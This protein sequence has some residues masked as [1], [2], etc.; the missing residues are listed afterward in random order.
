M[1]MYYIAWRILSL[2]SLIWGFYILIIRILPAKYI[3]KKNFICA[4][5]EESVRESDNSSNLRN[6]IAVQ[7]SKLDTWISYNNIELRIFSA[8]QQI[9]LILR[10]P[11]CLWKSLYS[12]IIVKYKLQVIMH[13]CKSTMKDFPILGVNITHLL[14]S[15][16]DLA[17]IS[18]QTKPY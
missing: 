1:H 14:I 12:L 9:I 7:I 2:A 10:S 5:K 18:R 11:S 3:K 16:R 15:L 17:G 6:Q 13:V 8:A 4:V